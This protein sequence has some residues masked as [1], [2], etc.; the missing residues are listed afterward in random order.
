M[1]RNSKNAFDG[2]CLFVVQVDGVRDNPPVGV[3]QPAVGDGAVD[4]AVA[5]LA[6][7]EQHPAREQ[8]RVRRRVHHRVPH[9]VHA[10]RPVHVVEARGMH[11]QPHVAVRGVDEHVI[12]PAG[13]LQM[14][15]GFQLGGRPVVGHVV[16]A[17]H[18]IA[19]VDHHVAGKGQRIA[20]PV[21]VLRLP[22]HGSSRLRRR[23]RHG[24]WHQL[25][26]GVV[27]K[28]RGGRRSRGSAAAPV[29]RCDAGATLVNTCGACAPSCR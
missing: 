19:V 13:H 22:F 28:F 27:G 2:R 7:L 5:A 6:G 29:S 4:D 3:G 21:L 20:G 1:P 10:L 11:V 12:G 24:Q 15:V 25:L 18:V 9:G 26:A 23:F 16:G 14:A 8:Q 17:N